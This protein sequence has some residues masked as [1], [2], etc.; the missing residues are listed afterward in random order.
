[1]KI[2]I[3]GSS[4]EISNLS[5]SFDKKEKLTH[6][7]VELTLD[8]SKLAEQVTA[9][10]RATLSESQKKGRTFGEIKSKLY[11]FSNGL[12]REMNDQSKPKSLTETAD[13]YI[14]NYHQ[15][16]GIEIPDNVKEMLYVSK[17]DL[18]NAVEEIQRSAYMD[19]KVRNMKLSELIYVTEKARRKKT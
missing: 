2:I 3:E 5:E 8:S 6:E 14:C 15:R 18:K 4:E 12:C 9:S 7:T 10:C 17:A 1:M 11:V 19:S 13:E 16:S